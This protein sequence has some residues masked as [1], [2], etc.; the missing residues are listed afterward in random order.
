MLRD[1][2][3]FDAERALALRR[4][5]F[6]GDIHG[7]L[8]HIDQALLHG[9]AALTQPP[10]WL[11]LLGDIELGGTQTLRDALAPTRDI[12]PTLKFAFVH[13]NHDAD[14]HGHWARLHACGDAVALHGQVVSLDGIKVAGIG[15]NF[16]GRVW[17]PPNLPTYVS[18]AQATHRSAGE[19]ARGQQYAPRLN[20]AIYKDEV[21]RLASQRA[22]ILVTHEAFSCHPYGW[23]VL[24]QLARDWPVNNM[25]QMIGNQCSLSSSVSPSRPNTW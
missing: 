4:L 2:S 10:S 21:D 17:A 6:A 22:D 16:L 3:L 18:R 12:E 9:H 14:T 7:N 13:G 23:E 20:G 1:T 24:D 11:A 8:D 25:D 19:V 15:G 5:W